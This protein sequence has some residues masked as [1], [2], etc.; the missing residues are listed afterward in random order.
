M[1]GQNE[2]KNN[3]TNEILMFES[4]PLEGDI[5]NGQIRYCS[6]QGGN[7][8]L[9]KTR[10]CIILQA[11]KYNED[12]NNRIFVVPMS[13]EK[14]NLSTL[15]DRFGLIMN[16]VNKDPKLSYVCIDR[17]IFINRSDIGAVMG[18]APKRLLVAICEVL[19]ARFI[20]KGEE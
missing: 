20:T 9:H 18:E 3:E 4:S 5:K 1:I 6:L 10:P 14:D 19:F 16:Y 17:A 12:P 8:N 13:S 15:T 2:L 11:D 7:G